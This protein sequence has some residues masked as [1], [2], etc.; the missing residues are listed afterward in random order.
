MHLPF[1]IHE[2]VIGWP[3]RTGEETDY[4]TFHIHDARQSVG[5]LSSEDSVLDVP[6]FKPV[7]R[8]LEK[9]QKRLAVEE[10]NA[11]YASIIQWHVF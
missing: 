9:R 5:K 1:N 3:A 10:L 2:T 6:T 11:L 4:K 7:A 8:A